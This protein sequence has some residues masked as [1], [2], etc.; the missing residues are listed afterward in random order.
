MAPKSWTWIGA[1]RT[2]VEQA[3][4]EPDMVGGP[5]AGY[6]IEKRRLYGGLSDGVDLVHVDNG[7]LR[8]DVLASRGMGIWKMW[9]GDL[10]VGWNSPVRGPVHPQLVPLSDPSGLGWLDGF[11]ELFVRCGLESNGAAEFSDSGQVRYG[12]HGRIANKPAHQLEVSADG[13]TGQLAVSGVVD[14]VRFHFFK[15]R[16]F[17]TITTKV[18]ETAV[19]VRDTIQNLSASPAEFQ[20]LYHINIGP[21]VLGNG[22]EVVVPVKRMMPRDPVAVP[23]LPRWTSYGPPEPGKPEEAFYFDLQAD[24]Q[25]QTAVLLKNPHGDRGVSVHFNTRQLPC[26]TLWKNETAEADGYVTGLE[27]ATNYPNSRSFETERGRVV[28]LAPGGTYTSEVQL[29]VHPTDE[30][31]SRTQQY[32]QSLVRQPAK[33]QDQPQRE[34]CAGA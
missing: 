28:S 20:L 4:I 7:A 18:G 33:I 24:D 34:W 5:Q 25:Q 13:E 31:V 14:E 26:F 22:S 30:A 27:P 21:P 8:F 2:Y 32:V 3:R 16:M 15:L 23:G 10:C 29:Q 11:D 9:A 12:L 1:D 17:T 19:T 6:L